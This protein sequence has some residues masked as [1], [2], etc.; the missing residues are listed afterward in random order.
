MAHGAG[1]LV[2]VIEDALG[3]RVGLAHDLGALHHAFG[4]GSHVLHQGIGFLGPFGQELLPF[5]Q[6][7][8]GLAQLVGQAVQGGLEESHHFLA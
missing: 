3:H 6:E 4:L 7:P 8:A 2:G 1:I 5:P